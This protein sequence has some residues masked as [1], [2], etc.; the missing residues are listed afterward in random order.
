MF[1]LKVR[2]ADFCTKIKSWLISV[3]SIARN[4]I[5]ATS[6]L[7]NI[8][9]NFRKCEKEGKNEAKP[10]KN[11]QNF[12]VCAGLLVAGALEAAIRH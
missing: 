9:F 10:G 11:G 5:A 4:T 12:K 1:F 2:N 6:I 7:Q 3:R 8:Q